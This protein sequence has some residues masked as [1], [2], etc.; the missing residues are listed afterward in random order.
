MLACIYINLGYSQEICDDINFICVHFQI[1]LMLLE[2]VKEG[3]NIINRFFFHLCFD[4][5]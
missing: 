3:Q 5:H 1:I 4:I 2:M